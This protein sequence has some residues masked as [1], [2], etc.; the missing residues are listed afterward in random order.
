MTT[1]VPSLSELLDAHLA[2]RSAPVPDDLRAEFEQALAAHRALQDVLHETVLEPSAAEPD[3]PPPEV[4]DDYQIERELGRGGMGVVYLVR[5]RSLN[6]RVA[7]K[8]LRPGERAFGAVL[9]RFRDEAQHLARLRHPHIVT[10]H[11]VGEA[12]GEPYFT[13]DYVDGEPLSALLRHGPLS[14]TQAVEILKQ[15]AGA[16]QHA[17]KQGIIHRDLKPGNVLIDRS[18][19]VFVTDFGLARDLSQAAH[20]TETGELLGTPQYMAP[21]Q[22][23]GQTE[24][25][26]E[27]TDIHALGMLLFE[28]LAGRP[29]FGAASPADVLVRLL[30]E[31]PPALRGIDRRIPRDLET[32]ALKCLQKSPAARYA[33][34]SALLE[35]VRRFES[36]EPL[37]ARRTGVVTRAARW[38]GR[39]WRM[40]AAVVLT[41]AVVLA[42]APRLFDKSVEQLIA[43]GDEELRDGRPELAARVF[44]RAWTRSDPAQRALLAPQF[45]EAV[46]QLDNGAE[47]VELALQILDVA[48]ESS[49]G[50]HNYVVAQSLVMAARKE[51]PNGAFDPPHGL[52]I[53]A[54]QLARRE[55]AA[56]RLVLFLD[57]PWGTQD[58]RAEAERSLQAIDRSLR[59]TFPQ[60]PFSKD[61]LAELPQGS[62]EELAGR[63]T[64][65]ALSP[66]ERGKA[67]LA[68]AK[69][70]EQAG[71]ATAALEGY[72]DALSMLRQVFP[73]VTGVAS[74]LQASY[75]RATN[76]AADSPECRLVR[77]LLAAI[78]R[79]DSEYVDPAQGGLRLLFDHP[80]LLTGF[81]IAISLELVDS[82]LADPQ[83][84]LPRRLSSYVP[85]HLEDPTEI[86]VLDGRYRLRVAGNS[87]SY[88]SPKVD[89]NLLDLTTA[90]W[91]EEV[92]IRGG[93]V[94]LPPIT[95]RILHEIVALA[96]AERSQANLSTDPIAW[97][98][99]PGAAWYEVQLGY[100]TDS[101][102]PG[103]T[104]FAIL[105]SETPQLRIPEQPERELKNLRQHWTRGRTA[106][107][108][109]AAF[110]DQGR[111]IATTTSERQFLIAQSLPETR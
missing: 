1:P 107:F 92:E 58:E 3:R 33:N 56:R 28:M 82:T 14:P 73:F 68:A 75:S 36:G 99:V 105:R 108:R 26:G 83:S 25:I 17:H 90:D 15:V 59:G 41:A 86:R 22:A 65:T 97:N 62:L 46:S 35:D 111:R 37:V 98:S 38:V 63:Q 48:P 103:V 76:V 80:E 54:E 85:M 71:H 45:A 55:R 106:L 66:W 9:K 21:E 34:V 70:H 78:E 12:A 93:L 20:L 51:E 44:Q 96:P 88:Q 7:L 18:G 47:A 31:E 87:R 91:P 16:V 94:E 95:V 69:L 64:D 101:P 100:L 89:P 81:D 52:P 67:A 50:K 102:S 32:I 79:L 43:W 10:I 74:T 49:F 84:G 29:A 77:D 6:R 30:N 40:A 109:V 8:V 72:R 42:V 11:E 24:L 19:R 104:Y 2:G 4:P 110:D 61:E 39:H 13:M 53:P 57:G 23:R 27:A 60:V 5:Q